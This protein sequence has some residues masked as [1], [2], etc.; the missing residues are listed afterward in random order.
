V[1]GFA[2]V[3]NKAQVVLLIQTAGKSFLVDVAKNK[4]K[5]EF[6]GGC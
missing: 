2:R 4:Q 6:V 1:R 3:K 5:D